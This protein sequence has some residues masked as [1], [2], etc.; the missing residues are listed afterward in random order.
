VTLPQLLRHRRAAVR[1]QEAVHLNG[2][3]LS[4]AAELRARAAQQPRPELA[5]PFTDEAE[6]FE[7]AT[8]RVEAL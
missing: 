3:L 1:R 5:R 7:A 8:V 2:A 4:T 6:L